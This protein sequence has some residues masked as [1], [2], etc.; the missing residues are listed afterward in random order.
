[1]LTSSPDILKPG[2]ELSVPWN[3]VEFRSV[4]WNSDH[5]YCYVYKVVARA[6]GSDYA[7]ASSSVFPLHVINCCSGSFNGGTPVVPTP[8][9]K[10]LPFS[11]WV[12]F[13]YAAQYL[14][15]DL[16]K[17]LPFYRVCQ[18]WVGHAVLCATSN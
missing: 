3:S 14:Q 16:G 4:P 12:S 13:M 9:H 18:N 1:M 6:L 8:L 10:N 11:I 17:Y 15:V 5:L 7:L 2:D